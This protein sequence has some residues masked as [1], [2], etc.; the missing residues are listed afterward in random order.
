METDL[1]NL[2][3]KYDASQELLTTTTE[4]LA[5]F[6]KTVSKLD[7]EYQRDEDEQMRC[8]ISIDGAKEHVPGRP[9]TIV[10]NLLNRSRC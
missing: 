9:K 10:T 7:T 3:A 6:A 1:A 5:E 4:A 8:Q 2:Q